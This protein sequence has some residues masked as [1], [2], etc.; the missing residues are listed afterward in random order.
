[1]RVG[2]ARWGQATG[3]LDES[4]IRAQPVIAWPRPREH[5]EERVFLIERLLRKSDRSIH[6]SGSGGCLCEHRRLNVFASASGFEFA[7]SPSV[8][9]LVGKAVAK[10]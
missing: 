10:P 1:M 7:D 8:P 3:Y 2:R 6:I 4:G 5:H 9:K